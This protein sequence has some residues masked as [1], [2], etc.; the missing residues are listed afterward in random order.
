MSVELRPL[1][2]ICNIQCVYCYQ[3]PQRDAGSIAHS[4]D[5]EKMKAGIEAEGGPFTLFGGEPLLLPLEDLEDLWAWGFEKYKKN[6]VQ[7]NGTLI[8]DEHIQLLHKYNVQIGI[9]VDGPGE[10][11]DLRWHG[12][13][14]T[15]RE[16]T[17]KSQASIERLCK[18][19][20]P[21]SLIITLHR[22]NALPDKL[23]A[24]L[25]WVRDLVRLGVHAI[26]LHL[27]ESES[28]EIRSRYGLTTEENLNALMAFLNLSRELSRTRF[29][30][31]V[32][33]RNLL[34]ADDRTA[35]CVWNACDPYT[36]RAVRGVEG[37]GQRS[38]CGR[39]NKDGIDFVK[40]AAPGFERYIALYHTPQEVGGCK[41]CRFFLMCK[42]QC[43]GTAIDGDW[44]NRTEHCDVWKGLYAVLEDELKADGKLPLSLRPDRKVIEKEAIQRW[45]QGHY[46]SVTRLAATAPAVEVRAEGITHVSTPEQTVGG[47][48]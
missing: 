41:D 7:T 37:H 48:A 6:T 15:T 34:M 44:R 43:P 24:L 40:S 10:L 11:N 35:L 5:M 36:T 38:N 2:V 16:S 39:T 26:G 8:S 28:A 3:H 1:G 30:L 46:V 42:G 23:P 12:N 14:T 19:G 32:D 18:E 31:F 29:S 25:E 27:L 20:R 4:Y 9:S 13:L 22:M 33:M 45:T 21:P 47:A 17:A